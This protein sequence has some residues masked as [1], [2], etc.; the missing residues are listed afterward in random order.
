MIKI[1]R[2]I[3]NKDITFKAQTLSIKELEKWKM[4]G[5]IDIKVEK[6]EQDI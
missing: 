1:Y 2:T 6:D 5:L 3:D 4:L